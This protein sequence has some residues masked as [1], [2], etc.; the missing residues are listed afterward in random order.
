LLA[1]SHPQSALPFFA[2]F[3]PPHPQ[4]DEPFFG[5]AV[6]SHPQS[7]QAQPGPPIVCRMPFIAPGRAMEDELMRLDARLLPRIVGRAAQ[8]RMSSSGAVSSICASRRKIVSSVP[9]FDL[10]GGHTSDGT[11]SFSSSRSGAPLFTAE[12]G[13]TASSAHVALSYGFS[14]ASPCFPTHVRFGCAFGG[15][16]R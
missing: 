4:S 10:I 11:R 15:A 2:F 13:A 1:P 14:V 12:C 7:E 9:V 16:P 6:P 8:A 3:A 5:L